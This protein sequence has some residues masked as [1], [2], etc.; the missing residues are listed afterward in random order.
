MVRASYSSR[1]SL[2]VHPPGVYSHE[3]NVLTTQMDYPKLK[4]SKMDYP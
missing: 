4:W 1:L 3:H 2:G